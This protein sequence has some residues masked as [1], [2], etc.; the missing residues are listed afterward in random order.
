MPTIA[1][2]SP[3]CYIETLRS[4]IV[5]GR[6]LS[7][8][9]YRPVVVPL[10]TT[11]GA[12]NPRGSASFFIPS[13]QRFLVFQVIPLVVPVSLS[14]PLDATSGVFNVGIPAA[15]DVIAGGT[16]E[17]RLLTKAM[18][19]RINLAMVSYSFQVFPQQNFALSDL[20]S[21]DGESPSLF[22][23]PAI[24][25]QGTNIDLQAAL[26][27]VSAAGADTKYG[28]ILVGAYINVGN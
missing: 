13:N 12:S 5:E 8:D 28:I 14:D 2:P 4:R 18:N 17:D 24:L 1:P 9:Q 26:Q 6:T 3:D 27:D 11:L 22:D 20:S 25:P 16:I 21:V 7:P 19:C 23:M 15:G 10:Q